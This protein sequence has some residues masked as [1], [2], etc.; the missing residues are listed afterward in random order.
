M[1]DNLDTGKQF[2][3]GTGVEPTALSMSELTESELHEAI[4]QIPVDPG[5]EQMPQVQISG[6]SGQ[7]NAMMRLNHPVRIHVDGAL[8]DYAF[9]HCA[10]S[11]IRLT[12]SA[13]HGV[14][15]GM[16]SGTIRIRGNVGVGAGASMQGGTLAVYGSAG[17][18]FGAAMRGG[19]SFV[20]G[21]C[22]NDTGIGALRGTIVIGGDAGERLGDPSNSVTIFIR[23]KAKSLAAGVTEAPLRKPEQLKL[24]LLLINASIRGE[25]TDFRRIIPDSVLRAEESQRGE[26]NPNW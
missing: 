2:V 13:G 11:D 14:A 17:D 26:I 25:P 5:S 22:G 16:I 19:G 1:S 20:R 10:Q 6:A 7:A 23:G 15:E 3:V 8:G 9:A 12:G 21:N 4:H 24:G 18:R